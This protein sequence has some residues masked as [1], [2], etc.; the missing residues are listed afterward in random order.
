MNARLC[1]LALSAVA[2]LGCDPFRTTFKDEEPAVDYQAADVVDVAAPAG[3]LQVTTWNLKY[4]G[5]R[6][7][8][9]WECGGDR[10]NMTEG[11]VDTTMQAIAAKVRELDPDIL[12]LQEV[13]RLAQRTAYVDQVQFLL[14]NSALNYGVYAS[15]W[16]ADYIPTDGLG[17]TDTGNAILSKW[18][19]TD[20]VRH[21]LPLFTEQDPIT[22]YF[23]LR[24]NALVAKVPDAGVT[25]IGV[26]TAAFSQ[27]GTKKLHLEKFKELLDAADAA[28]ELV[29]GGGDLNSVPRNSPMVK[30]FPEDQGCTDSMFPGD[31]Y[32]K[33]PTEEE[34]LD[35]LFGS[36]EAAIPQV[37][38]DANPTDYFTYVGGNPDRATAEG[39]PFFWNRKLDF[40]FTNTPNGF[41]AAKVHQ[42]ANDGLDTLPLSDHA[43]IVTTLE[44]N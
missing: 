9:F 10:Y 12:I 3:P 40:L 28:G 16:K 26:H 14:D 17:P 37:L 21:Q 41:S 31:D 33:D 20:A 4:G 18:P 13:D 25:V 29:V 2:L 15:Q 42:D 8:F 34:W 23:Y 27:D 5:A 22:K 43:P 24:R 44:V 35:D 38:F 6:F 19:L 36:Y 30:D 7:L 32:R 39:W 1:V 11:E